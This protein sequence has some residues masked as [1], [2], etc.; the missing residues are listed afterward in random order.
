VTVAS[1]VDAEIG[2]FTFSAA[3]ATNEVH[4]ISYEYLPIPITDKM[5]ERAA[6]FLAAFYAVLRIHGR[7]TGIR[8]YSLGDL[9]VERRDTVGREFLDRYLQTIHQIRRKQIHIVKGDDLLEV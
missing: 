1:I 8:R 5:I 2:K 6:T 4:Y 7:G 3:P 9:T